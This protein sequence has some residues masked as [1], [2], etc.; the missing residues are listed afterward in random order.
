MRLWLVKTLRR[1]A[2]WLE[3]PDPALARVRALVLSVETLADARGVVSGERKRHRVL[4]QLVVEFPSMRKRD[5]ALLI[6]RVLQE[7]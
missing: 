7:S 4:N 6:E 1:L 2:D 5:L 3:P